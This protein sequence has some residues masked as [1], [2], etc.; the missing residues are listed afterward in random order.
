MD[1]TRLQAT[2]R[3]ACLQCTKSK[4][5]CDRS[6]PQCLRCLDKGVQCQYPPSRRMRH[7]QVPSVDQGEPLSATSTLQSF[8]P[9]HDSQGPSSD[10]Q[11]L[12]VNDRWLLTPDSFVRLLHP[13]NP[14]D[15][16]YGYNERIL[17][18]ETVEWLD[19][20]Q[21]WMKQWVTEGH[22]PVVHRSLY[23]GGYMPECVEDAFTVMAT[24]HSSTN[25][26][27]RKT[28]L[29]IAD[30]R[31]SK[32]IASF[33][34]RAS[35]SAHEAENPAGLCHE[36]V[37]VDTQTHIARTLALL[38]YQVMGL[39]DTDIRARSNAEDYMETLHSWAA[40]ML[41]SAR[42]DSL[43]A[44][45]STPSD[46]TEQSQ[47]LLMDQNTY[48]DNILDNTSFMDIMNMDEFLYFPNLFPPTT[49]L[50]MPSNDT[51]PG[52]SPNSKNPFILPPKPTAASPST[53]GP[54]ISQHHHITSLHRAWT[55]AESVRRISLTSIYTQ[56]VYLT[57]KRGVETTDPSA[58]NQGTC[59]G[60]M[61][62]TARQGLWDAP[63]AYRWFNEVK[64]AANAGEGRGL[65][66]VKSTEAWKI[67]EGVVKV[68]PSDVDC[69]TRAVLFI[70]FGKEW[71]MERWMDLDNNRD[72]DGGGC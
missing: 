4:R 30:R 17:G 45:I 65:L 68:R 6:Y 52:P 32:L 13:R 14:I 2:K 61:T 37:E 22:S 72:G 35:M 67:L 36:T 7:L 29:Q 31:A 8:S 43:T 16:P 20:V 39:L 70:C 33:R 46:D 23:S 54:I 71:V 69:F 60:G 26:Q 49:S 41:E 1:T 18:N 28:A 9:R 55:I 59:P 48:P 25:P 53:S 40:Q 56:S 5:K 12:L 47:E 57:L 27:I 10:S 64:K 42:L 58:E 38:T 34:N 24:Y 62:F 50:P 63:S 21:S 11:D 44:E 3:K 66:M 19:T 51:A 15:R